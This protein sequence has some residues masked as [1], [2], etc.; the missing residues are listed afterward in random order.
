[1]PKD[2]RP[3][4]DAI[5]LDGAAIVN[6]IKPG[7]AKTFAAYAHDVFL[8]H[9]PKQLQCAD[10]RLDLVWDEHQ[11]DSLKASTRE[12][13]GK[14]V[15]RRVEANTFIPGNWQE[16]LRIDDNKSELF[17]FLAKRAVTIESDK[18]VISTHGKNVLCNQPLDTTQ[19]Q[20][21]QHEEADTRMMVH[22]LDASMQG[23]Q[24]LLLRTVQR[25]L[26]LQ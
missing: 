5:I 21:C 8:P 15:R 14:G 2:E 23:C 3:T 7:S 25:L 1:M 22:M 17:T 13:R 9:L 26:F 18:H 4:G 16:F 24:K 6:M 10:R 12:R 11:A 20:P 19:L